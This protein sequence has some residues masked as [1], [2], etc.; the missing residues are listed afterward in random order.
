MPFVGQPYH[1]N[2][3]SSS[4]SSPTNLVVALETLKRKALDHV[5]EDLENLSSIP[6]IV[7][8]T[9]KFLILT[10]SLHIYI[11]LRTSSLSFFKKAT[12][13]RFPDHGN[14]HHC[15]S[16]LLARALVYFL[17]IKY[18]SEPSFADFCCW[19]GIYSYFLKWF[20]PSL[21]RYDRYVFN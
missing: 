16:K 15:T 14:V 3:S 6:S 11:Y 10:N 18:L 5:N 20:K 4:S 7:Q 1:K 21:I 9:Q 17:L 13:G 2:N 8:E 12:D 19:Q